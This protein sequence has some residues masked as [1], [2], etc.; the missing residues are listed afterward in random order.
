MFTVCPKCTL[1]LAV[2]AA[3]LRAGQGYVRCGRCTNV[4]NALLQL[5][6]E[7]VDMSPAGPPPEPDP[8]ADSTPDAHS[9]PPAEN[10]A[11]GTFETIVLEGDAITQ[12]EEVVPQET[13]NNEIAALNQRLDQAQG[14]DEDQV[15]DGGNDEE[16]FI[17]IDEAELEPPPPPAELPPEL[18]PPAAPPTQRGR[19][20]AG[21]IALAVLLGLQMLHHWR[22]DLA[23]SPAWGGPLSRAYA[24]LG[25]PLQPHWDLSAYDVRQ[26]GAR[27]DA[28]NGNAIQIRVSLANRAARAQPLPIL[29]LTLLDRY[30][31]RVAARDLEPAEYLPKAQPVRGFLA[32]DE[33]IDTQIAVQ[34]PGTDTTSFEIDTCLRGRGGLRCTDESLSLN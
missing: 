8:G 29:R 1:T 34:D 26:Q 31:K 10:P 4:F 2:T 6:D 14:Q 19:W 13:I 30:G 25:M 32:A 33:R 23:T 17:L 18:E 5:S 9:E 28:A 27:A 22:N 7:P 3:D 24:A 12:T 20:I 15:A 11:T 16:E 21:S